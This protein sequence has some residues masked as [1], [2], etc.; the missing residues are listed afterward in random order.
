MSRCM[1]KRC[2]VNSQSRPPPRCLKSAPVQSSRYLDTTKSNPRRADQV[3]TFDPL[4]V[5]SK[6]VCSADR[7]ENSG[8]IKHTEATIVSVGQDSIQDAAE[9]PH[10]ESGESKKVL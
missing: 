8:Q 2:I 10:T 4:S 3:I 6:N 1:R 5:K 7:K 9:R